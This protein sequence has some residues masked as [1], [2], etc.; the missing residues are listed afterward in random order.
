MEIEIKNFSSPDILDFKHFV[1]TDKES[2]S[3]LLELEIG[4]KGKSGADL[5]SVEVCTPK[6]LVENYQSIDIVFGRHKIIVFKYDID[7]VIN[8]FSQYL[9]S[10]D[11]DSWESI[12]NQISKMAHWEFEDYKK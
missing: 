7:N 5:F 3:F 8:T 11:D 1:P 2:F 9:N 10:L 4:I 12:V 6:W